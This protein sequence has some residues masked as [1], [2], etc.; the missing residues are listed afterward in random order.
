MWTED[1]QTIRIGMT[2]LSKFWVIIRVLSEV[3]S[4]SLQGWC[5]IRGH[6][7]SNFSLTQY[8]KNKSKQFVNCD[9]SLAGRKRA[10]EDFL[11]LVSV[12][13]KLTLLAVVCVGSADAVT[14]TCSIIHFTKL[15]LQISEASVTSLLVCERGSAAGT[16]NT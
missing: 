1:E 13:F 8:C 15:F 4:S 9:G 2:R 7:R 14:W 12:Y 10:K 6:V 16:Q 11:A 3:I 5:H